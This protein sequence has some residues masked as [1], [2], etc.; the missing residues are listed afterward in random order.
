[1]YAAFN[2]HKNADFKPYLLKSTDA[3]KSWTSIAGDLPE[4]GSV[5]AIAEDH[6]NPN[7]LFAGTEFGLYVTLD[8]G[9][10][11]QR[12][13]DGLPTIAVRDVCI[14]KQMNDLVVGTFGRGIYIL[15]DYSALRSLS[16]EPKAT[17]LYSTREAVLFVPSEQYGLKGKAF[18]GESLY[19]ADNPAYGATFTYYLKDALKTK[20][21][22]RQEAEKKG[23]FKYPSKEELRA[24]A[25]EEEPAILL[26]ITDNEGRPL[27]TVTGPVTAGFHRVAWDLRDPSIF[28]KSRGNEEYGGLFG[29]EDRGPFIFPGKYLVSMSKRVEGKEERL[30][31]PVEFN[32]VADK[33]D[34]ATDS[35]RKEL[36]E[37]QKQVARLQRA[38]HA[39]VEN[40]NELADKLGKAKQAL[41]QVQAP[42]NNLHNEIRRLIADNREILKELR[43]D[44][45]LRARNEGTPPSIQER[46]EEVVDQQRYSIAKPTKTQRDAYSIASEGLTDELAKLRKLIETDFKKVEAELERIGAPY[47][48]GRLPAWKDK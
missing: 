34:P 40:A 5:W 8:G 23:D 20:K 30:A 11:W 25:E 9:K 18:Q 16:A 21:Q 13:K 22:V 48:P 2:N 35:E 31:G 43:G 29:P 24:E 41:D 3:G 45:V 46:V 27:R 19:A 17:A 6:V 4:R 39:T 7:L 38:V 28:L 10:K 42:T 26:K 47:T 14:Q 15:D 44:S 1:V 37:F 32:V 36:R 33:L 12:L